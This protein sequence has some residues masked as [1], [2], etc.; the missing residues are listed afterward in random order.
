MRVRAK[1]GPA[2]CDENASA[3]VVNTMKPSVAQPATSTK[4]V[5]ADAFADSPSVVT[6]S[7]DRIA[8]GLVRWMPSP[9]R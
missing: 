5:H 6:V 1:N 2:E 7:H 4:L 3:Y 8:F 9:C